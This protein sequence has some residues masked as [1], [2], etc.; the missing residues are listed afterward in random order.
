MTPRHGSAA[1]SGFE[2]LLLMPPPSAAGDLRQPSAADRRSEA[3]RS[4]TQR[5]RENAMSPANDTS[6]A[7]PN[8]EPVASTTEPRSRPARLSVNLGDEPAAALREIMANRN[9]TATEAVRRAISLLK[10]VEDEQRAGNSIAV[11]ERPGRH[12]WLRRLLTLNWGDTR[13]VPR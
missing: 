1:D 7:E 12:G 4:A 10:F 8:V 6:R 9:I 13:A 5:M 2:G 11:V 3:S